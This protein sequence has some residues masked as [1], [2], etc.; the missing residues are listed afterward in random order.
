MPA[1]LTT[2]TAEVTTA[3]VEIKTLTIR[4]KQVTLAVFRQLQEEA[5]VRED[6]TLTGIPWG[7]VNYH[8]DKCAD[9]LPPH[10]HVVWQLGSELRRA[11]VSPIRWYQEE[12][13]CDG[14]VDEYYNAALSRADHDITHTGRF[15]DVEPGGKPIRCLEYRFHGIRC[16]TSLE[17]PE[18][19][20]CS[21]EEFALL[22]SEMLEA[23]AA[24]AARRKR[25]DAQFQVLSQLPQLFIAV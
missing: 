11:K 19:M 24:E 1:V 13:Y 12:F 10:L 2:E 20:E 9:E 23:A 15:L 7:R 8:P 17:R 3:A 4:G 14:L 18:R 22:K 21:D 5:L 6:G 25:I 16:T